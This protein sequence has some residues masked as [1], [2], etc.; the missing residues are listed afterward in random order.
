MNPCKHFFELGTLFFGQE[1]EIR[2][3]E[4][5]WVSPQGRTSPASEPVRPK[6]FQDERDGL[7]IV[8]VLEFLEPGFHALGNGL[9]GG[10]PEVRV[11]VEF[12]LK[13]R[14]G[15]SNEVG[16]MA[17]RH[18][19]AKGI[20]HSLTI[21]GVNGHIVFSS[22]RSEYAL[23]SVKKRALGILAVLSLVLLCASLVL[24]AGSYFRGILYF[25]A[26]HETPFG[27]DMQYGLYFR[28]MTRFVEYGSGRI[29]FQF[30]IR[31]DPASEPIMQEH[32][33][34]VMP[35]ALPEMSLTSRIARFAEFEWF[36]QTDET[37]Y[38]STRTWGA[39]VPLWFVPLPFAISPMIWL[40]RWMR[41]GPVLPERGSQAA[42]LLCCEHRQT[43]VPNIGSRIRCLARNL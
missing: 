42:E 25:R 20:N 31:V 4:N 40:V 41:S 32:I 3:I 43:L 26:P 12:L 8:Q 14:E 13:L 15:N 5:D 11:G 39:A 19:E 9:A 21:S 1:G 7:P 24:W 2:R 37:F 17:Q 27:L 30:G 10:A 34:W 18:P 28:E 36:S 38:G 16:G 33:D 29:C 23:L 35:I 22:G 6:R